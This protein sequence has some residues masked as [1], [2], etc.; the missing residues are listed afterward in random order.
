[1]VPSSQEPDYAILIAANS[2]SHLPTRLRLR[3]TKHV[4]PAVI[5][6]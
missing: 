3:P 6:E 4:V 1:M 2:K 5:D